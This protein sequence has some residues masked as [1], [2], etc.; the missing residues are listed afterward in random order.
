MGRAVVLHYR[1]NYWAQ[2]PRGGMTWG[3]GSDNRA[4]RQVMA[5]IAGNDH[6]VNRHLMWPFTVA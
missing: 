2:M 5:V 3:G 6:T 1:D 4:T